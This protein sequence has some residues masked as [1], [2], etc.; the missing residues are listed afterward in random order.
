[1]LSNSPIYDSFVWNK[2]L[3]FAMIVWYILLVIG[4]WKVFEKAGEE[5]WKALI[6]FYNLYILFKISNVAPLF[7]VQILCAGAAAVA[8]WLAH[9]IFLFYPIGWMLSLGTV[10]ISFYMWYSL[11]RAFG[12]GL[13]FT[14]G[15]CFLNP[16]FIMI[17]GYGGSRYYLSSWRF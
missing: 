15:L 10:F 17:L 11:S 6:P 1:M 16:I 13:G 7:L 4:L 8:Y 14:L 12:H 3:S 9:L 5:G 2:H